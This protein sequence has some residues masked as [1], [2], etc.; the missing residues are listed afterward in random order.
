MEEGYLEEDELHG[1]HDQGLREEGDG[2]AGAEPVEDS[3]E[4]G[5]EHDQRDVE[6]EA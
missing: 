3:E 6:R 1:D 2:E 5:E 4:G